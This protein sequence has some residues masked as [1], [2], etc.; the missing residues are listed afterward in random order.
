MKKK[1]LLLFFSA[2]VGLSMLNTAIA[3]E[4]NSKSGVSPQ[5]V[6][7]IETNRYKDQNREWDS[8]IGATPAPDM[9]GKIQFLGKEYQ[10]PV[11]EDTYVVRQVFFMEELKPGTKINIQFYDRDRF[12][13]DDVIAI[14]TIE[15]QG[16]PTVS[17]I[18]RATIRLQY[19]P[20]EKT[21]N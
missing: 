21:S 11:H 15:Y 17:D 7:E 1:S 14:G 6:I 3:E 5:F 18:E 13:L 8:T 4:K 9:Y 12:R 2:F 10:V 19:Y 20:P 16:S